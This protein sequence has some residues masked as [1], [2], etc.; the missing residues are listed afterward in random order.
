MFGNRNQYQSGKLAPN[1][2]NSPVFAVWHAGCRTLCIRWSRPVRIK[3]ELSQCTIVASST[4]NWAKPPSPASQPW[5]PW[6]S[7]R[8]SSPRHP[9]KQL[10]LPMTAQSSRSLEPADEQ[11]RSTQIKRQGNKIA[12]RAGARLP[13]TRPQRRR[14][15]PNRFAALRT[16]AFWQGRRTVK[17]AFKARCRNRGLASQPHSD[18]KSCS[19]QRSR[20]ARQPDEPVFRWSSLYG[21]FQPHS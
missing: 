20:V 18:A 19:R 9:R 7:C 12:F 15:G 5:S 3:R 13:S 2:S 17:S 1:P 11:A 14:S 4:A 10:R 16:L 6:F 8:A 21:H